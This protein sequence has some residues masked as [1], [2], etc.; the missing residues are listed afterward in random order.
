MKGTGRA[1]AGQVA[2]PAAT[3]EPL[4]QLMD[5]LPEHTGACRLAMLRHVLEMSCV[6]LD[7][8]L[9]ADPNAG[10]RTAEPPACT[11]GAGMRARSD[12][13]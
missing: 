8:M 7:G 10:R 4:R 12:A 1:I 3:A 6:A 5:E 11:C 13:R 2:G 9:S